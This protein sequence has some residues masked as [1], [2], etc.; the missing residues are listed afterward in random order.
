M[1][2]VLG[3]WK[4]GVAPNIVRSAMA[5]GV[6][7]PVNS[8]LKE[9]ANAQQLFSNPAIRDV[10]CALCSS[11]ATT[12]AI[13]PVDVVRTRLYAQPPPPEPKLYQNTM[14]CAYRILSTEGI[15]AFWKV[16]LSYYSRQCPSIITT[17]VNWG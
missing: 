3:L 17:K 8:K 15:L 6:A 14:H 1:T 2:G 5:T 13:N 16:P 4:R 9:M 12:F 10:C 7:L 11:F